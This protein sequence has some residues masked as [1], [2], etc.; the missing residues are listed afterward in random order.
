MT[1]DEEV[2]WFL[3][4][5]ELA[6]HPISP[7][8]RVL[9]FGCGDG[10]LVQA[11]TDRYD[12]F[13]CDIVLDHEDERLRRIEQD[14]VY[15]LPFDDA[16]FDCVLSQQV[17]EHVQDYNAVLIE[18]RRILK[19]GGVSIHI[20][21]PRMRI[22]EGHVF[23]PFASIVQHR[24][25]LGVWA[26]LGIRNQFQQGLPWR[27]VVE[28]NHAFLR[29]HT[30]YYTRRRVLRE[31]RA[32]FPRARLAEIEMLAATR[33]RVG[34]L[35]YAFAKRFPLLATGLSELRMRALLLS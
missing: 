2:A 20:F 3:R 12:A 29:D 17:F 13:G 28:L 27:E 26:R 4:V 35:A 10:A 11:L 9:D 14:P 16:S 21:P 6:G 7:G 19:P 34:R 30:T 1:K 33:R 24:A 23:V 8:A 32:V 5:L 31:A 22:R 15:R 18:L 25:W